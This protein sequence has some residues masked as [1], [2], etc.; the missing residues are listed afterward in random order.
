MNF[1]R[2]FRRIS[3]LVFIV[4]ALL[5]TAVAWLD[6]PGSGSRPGSSNT[7]GL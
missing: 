4:L 2:R 3:S 1:W 6:A 7:T 5:V